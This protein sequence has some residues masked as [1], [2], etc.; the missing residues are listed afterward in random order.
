MKKNY[1]APDIN[2]LYVDVADI[3]TTSGMGEQP[4]LSQRDKWQPGIAQ[5]V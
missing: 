4:D 1:Q 3:L 5:G 2:V